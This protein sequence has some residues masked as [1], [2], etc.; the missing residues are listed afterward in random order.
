MKIK[1]YGQ[2]AFLIV[3]EKGV[4]IIIDPYQ[5]GA[6]GG[7][8]AYGPIQDE[9]D[10]VLTSHEHAD[11]NYTGD[12][13]GKFLQIRKPGQY[14]ERGVAIRAVP[15]FH[16]KVKGKER[17]ENLIFVLSSDNIT[18][19]HLGD[20]GH[21]L[22]QN[23]LQTIGKIEVLCIPVGGFFTI[24]SAEATQVMDDIAPLITIPMHFS[25]EKIK[26]PIQPVN[27]F[28]EGKNNVVQNNA[29]EFLVTRDTL[30]KT[31]QIVVMKHA[32]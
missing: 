6:F 14:S 20:L 9:A 10:I 22:D 28:I 29:S 30:P 3:T 17:G 18:L 11:H 23:T 26:L 24:N 13:R 8:I 25:T 12:I 16:D 5:S 1:W 4:R 2:S 32:L 21:T 15:V 7:E 27:G 31:N 19:A